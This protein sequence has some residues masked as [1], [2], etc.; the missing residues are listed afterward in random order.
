MFQII[1]KGEKM[2]QGIP[3]NNQK[4]D[5]LESLKAQIE[6]LTAEKENLSQ[7][8]KDTQAAY[9]KGQQEISKLN[10]K[11]K[12]FAEQGHSLNV[13]GLDS[14]RMQELKDTDPEKWYEE[15]RKLELQAQ[16]NFED[17]LSKAQEEAIAGYVKSEQDILLA[18]FKRRNPNITDEFIRDCIPVGIQRKYQNGE[19]DFSGYLMEIEKFAKTPT[20]IGGETNQILNQP[21]LSNIGSGE[22]VLNSATGWDALEQKAKNSV[23]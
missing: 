9:T 6:A 20:V 19:L 11:L 13:E 21:N 3:E 8:F 2:G 22:G 12:V 17:R 14:E 15:R 1:L 4:T 10:A 16:K 7:R 5:T 18:D 23:I